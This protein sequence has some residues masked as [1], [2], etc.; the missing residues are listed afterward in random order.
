VDSKL[1]TTPWSKSVRVTVW[2][3]GCQIFWTQYTKAGENWDFWFE[4]IPS[5]NPGNALAKTRLN[6]A[7]DTATQSLVKIVWENGVNI[8]HTVKNGTC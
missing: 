4:N 1:Q 2:H 6:K 7:V 3:Q 5:G 8:N